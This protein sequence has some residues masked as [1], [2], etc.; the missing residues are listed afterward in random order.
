MFET[1]EKLCGYADRRSQT[2]YGMKAEE[3][4][5]LHCVTTY[6]IPRFDKNRPCPRAGQCD[7]GCQA[8]DTTPGDEDIAFIR[9]GYRRC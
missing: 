2:G 9:N 5:A 7:G 8:G 6:G 1:S 4:E 3:M